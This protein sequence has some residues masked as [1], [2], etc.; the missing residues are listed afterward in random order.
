LDFGPITAGREKETFRPLSGLPYG[1]SSKSGGRSIPVKVGTLEK[2]LKAMLLTVPPNQL[3]GVV[4]ETIARLRR[5][6]LYVIKGGRAET[7]PPKRAD[8]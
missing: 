3:D 6:R 5:Q 7:Q 8:T 2:K 1:R 4:K